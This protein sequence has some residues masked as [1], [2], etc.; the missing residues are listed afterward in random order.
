MIAASPEI[1]VLVLAAVLCVFMAVGL[2]VAFAMAG[3]AML[4]TALF[5]GPAGFMAIVLN[6]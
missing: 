6:V 1:S 4:I 3:S 2:P 5:G